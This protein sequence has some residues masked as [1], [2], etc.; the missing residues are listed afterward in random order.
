ML[1]VLGE[2]SMVCLLCAACSA[3][4]VKQPAVYEP[5]KCKCCQ[6]LHAPG[7]SPFGPWARHPTHHRRCRRTG[8][9]PVGMGRAP[10]QAKG[11]EER[12]REKAMGKGRGKGEVKETGRAKEKEKARAWARGRERAHRSTPQFC[13]GSMRGDS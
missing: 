12:G 11:G 4:L 6:S 10:G 9:M 7:R 1:G 8:P 3:N 2:L 5:L 13:P